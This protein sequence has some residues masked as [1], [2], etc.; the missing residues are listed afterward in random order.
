MSSI[1]PVDKPENTELAIGCGTTALLV[2]LFNLAQRSNAL[3]PIDVT[4][5]PMV[6]EVNSVQL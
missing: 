3:L 5:L 4:E 2:I 1:V 6:M